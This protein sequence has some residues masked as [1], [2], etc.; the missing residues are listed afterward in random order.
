MEAGIYISFE[1]L[2]D[3]TALVAGYDPLVDQKWEMCAVFKALRPENTVQLVSRHW[4]NH[5]YHENCEP[6]SS[7]SESE[8][9]SFNKVLPR[10]YGM[11]MKAFGFTPLDDSWPAQQHE[12]PFS[13]GPQK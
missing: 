3:E 6:L 12:F 9:E 4:R 10:F 2:D 8:Q 7:F 1:K 13:D 5:M 11:A